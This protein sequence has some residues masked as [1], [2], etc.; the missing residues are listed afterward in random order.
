MSLILTMKLNIM[1]WSL[2]LVNNFYP[3]PGNWGGAIRSSSQMNNLYEAISECGLLE[4]PYT[5][6]TFTW[7]HRRGMDMILEMLDQYLA[8]TG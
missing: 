4:L 3:I 5:G 6:S 2:I 8:T 1:F 7:S